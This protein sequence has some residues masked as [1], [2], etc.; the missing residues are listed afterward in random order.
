MIKD[1]TEDI[2]YFRVNKEITRLYKAFLVALKDLQDEH[3]IAQT[4][5][6]ENLPSEFEPFVNL[7]DWFT[8]EKFKIYRSKILSIGNETWRDIEKEL[9]RYEFNIKN[10][11]E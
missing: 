3:K 7:S 4:K 2:L 1:I 9:D 11:K 8:D 6:I 5:L 10:E